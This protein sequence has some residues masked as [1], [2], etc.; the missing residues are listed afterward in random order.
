MTLPDE[1][2]EEV[3]LSVVSR[4]PGE[5]EFHQAVR[6]VL[7]SLGP[8]LAKH[9]ELA[10]QRVIERI[11]EPERQIIFGVPW[12]DDR[13]QVQL[14]RGFR[15]QFNSALGPYKGGLRFHPS[16]YLGTVKFLGFEQTF[17][18]AL[19]GLPIGGGKGGS[20]FNPRGRSDTEI[21]RFCQSFMLELAR[22][23]G[24]YRDVPA[25]D[26][27]VGVRE[28]G[29]LFG[30]YKRI[31][32]QYQ[33]GTL[34][35]KG[36]GWGG[37]VVRKEAT[38]YG[39]VFFMREM[40]RERGKDLEGRTCVVSGSGNVAIYTIEKLQQ[41]GALVFACSDSDGYIYDAGGLDLELLKE[42]KE[43]ERLRISVYAERSGRAQYIEGGSVWEV[44]CD[45]A[46]PSATQNEL[47]GHDARSLVKGGC[48][49]VAE[50]ANMPCTPDAVKVFHDASVSFGLGKAA[51]AGGVAVS[52]LEMQQNASRDT[53]TF[54]YTEERLEQIMQGIHRLCSETAETYGSPGNYVRGANMASYIRVA[55]AMLSL[56]LA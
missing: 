25:G 32:K 44:P 36:L 26:I 41:L 45:L 20:D 30:M 43:R 54:E 1:R 37:S 19:T 47:N 22:D 4:N 56:G 27:G 55:E 40:L 21:M 16:V 23:L 29:Y 5:L 33:S 51:N 7:D 6:E 14:N 39:S 15:V 31:T 34:T 46:F 49:A 13:G 8:V 52:A 35:G 9:P 48:I 11:C 10:E 42:I 12:E 2:L 24:E 53:W 18:N 17:K 28:I 38:G 50:G 3:Y